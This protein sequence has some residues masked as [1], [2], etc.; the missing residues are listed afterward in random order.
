MRLVDFA[1]SLSVQE[2]KIVF[3]S[4]KNLGVVERYCCEVL[5]GIGRLRKSTKFVIKQ[6]FQEFMT[7]HVRLEHNILK[8]FF[9]KK[10]HAERKK[11]LFRMDYMCGDNKLFYKF[12]A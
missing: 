5:T 3:F 11:L 12:V 7:A 9:P 8:L 10:F 6:D 2:N 1:E 4:S